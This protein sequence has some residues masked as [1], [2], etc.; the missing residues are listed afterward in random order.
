MLVTE[1]TES[2]ALGW[3]YLGSN[4]SLLELADVLV[5]KTR[6]AYVADTQTQYQ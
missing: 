3:Q 1:V 2:L 6:A 4:G 5:P